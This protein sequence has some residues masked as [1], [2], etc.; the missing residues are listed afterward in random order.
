MTSLLKSTYVYRRCQQELPGL[1]SDFS[2][3]GIRQPLRTTSVFQSL[4]TSGQTTN[5][6]FNSDLGTVFG[7][8]DDEHFSTMPFPFGELIVAAQLFIFTR[9]RMGRRGYGEP[10]GTTRSLIRVVNSVKQ[11]SAERAG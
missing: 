4:T 6:R 3:L 10:L 5:I 8:E 11:D 7:T 1:L 9:T 2:R